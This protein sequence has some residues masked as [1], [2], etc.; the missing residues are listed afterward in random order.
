MKLVRPLVL[1]KFK[2]RFMSQNLAEFLKVLM[3]VIT[4]TAGLTLGRHYFLSIDEEDDAEDMDIVGHQ[5]NE[6]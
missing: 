2:E 1:Q 3:I 4:W 5:E 6:S